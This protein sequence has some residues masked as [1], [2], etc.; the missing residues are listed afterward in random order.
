MCVCVCVMEIDHYFCAEDNIIQKSIFHGSQKRLINTLKPVSE[1]V[2]R[3]DS[4]TSRASRVV[5][6]CLPS[7]HRRVS[8]PAPCSKIISPRLSLYNT[9]FNIASVVL[10]QVE[11][12]TFR[13]FKYPY[14]NVF[15]LVMLHMLHIH[16]LI[17]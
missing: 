1:K 8:S 17:Y 14:F 16:C 13:T 10:C 2:S 7:D 3:H 6:C 11:F 12:F 9:K 5:N 15:M 4:S